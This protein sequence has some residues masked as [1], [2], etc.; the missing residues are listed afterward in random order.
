MTSYSLTLMKMSWIDLESNSLLPKH[1]A[2]L[3]SQNKH[4]D[5][6]ADILYHLKGLEKGFVV[7]VSPEQR[8]LDALHD[9]IKDITMH[10]PPVISLVN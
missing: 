9:Q 3:A 6:L 4:I 10:S 5:T 1:W 7:M 2:N 8:H